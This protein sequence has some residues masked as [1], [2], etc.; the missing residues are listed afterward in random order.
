MVG[1]QFHV[2]QPELDA[3]P[4]ESGSAHPNVSIQFSGFDTLIP[5]RR[6]TP[7]PIG[8]RSHLVAHRVGQD[9][10]CLKHLLRV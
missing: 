6:H 4:L 1:G 2:I 5:S 10:R 8:Y 7:T 3:F 9:M